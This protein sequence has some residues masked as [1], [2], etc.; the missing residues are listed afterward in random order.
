MSLRCSYEQGMFANE[1]MGNYAVHAALSEME[2][3]C[4]HEAGHAVIDYMLGIGLESV[5]VY[6]NVIGDTVGHGGEVKHR[7]RQTT[8]ISFSYRPLHFRYGLSAAAGPAAERRY[9]H[10]VGLPQRLLLA[11]QGDHQIIDRIGKAIGHTG[12]CRFAFQRHIWSHAQRLIDSPDVWD[13][14]NAVAFALHDAA[15]LDIDLDADV[16]QWAF[17][18]PRN[19]YAECRKA[20]LRRGQLAVNSRGK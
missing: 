18:A 9:R 1:P 19:V 11:T 10:E 7:G 17:L 2:A 8:R 4:F 14:I 5:G 3:T 16:E 15:M 6:S 20:G 13:A 12:R